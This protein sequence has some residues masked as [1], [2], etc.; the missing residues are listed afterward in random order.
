MYNPTP[1]KVWNRVQN[2]CS[3]NLT[4]FVNPQQQMLYKGNILQ[5][6]GNSSSITKNQR[7][8]QIAK[9]KWTSRKKSWATQSVTYSN[10]NTSNL[11]R[12]NYS[13]IPTD[14]IND[15]SLNTIFNG[16]SLICS[17][18]A[19]SCTN[20]I[21]KQ[22]NN[23]ILS[24]NLTSDSDVPGPLKVL[25]W[26]NS[27]PTYFPR[28]TYK[29]TSV[30]NKFPVNYKGLISA[31]TPIPPILS[32]SGFTST[33]IS[34][35]WSFN[36]N[37]CIIPISSYN[38]YQNG[39]IINNV[40]FTEMSI[41]ISNLIS[42]I[43]YNFYITSLSNTIE[44]L[45]SNTITSTSPI[46]EIPIVLP[47]NNG[48]NNTNNNTTN[49]TNTYEINTTNLTYSITISNPMYTHYIIE[50][51]TNII[52]PTQLYDQTEFSILNNTQTIITISTNN[53]N[54]LIFNSPYN[55]PDGLNTFLINSNQYIK[56]IYSTKNWYVISS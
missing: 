50:S 32:L 39:Q 14:T 7:Y 40:P 41:T 55:P 11:L 43:T 47:I 30:G 3:L 18:I 2:S 38:I 21:I 28:Q 24:C 10:P 27:L 48:N 9:G 49:N 25:C 44:S 46:E 36:N 45:P 1:T 8:A 53:P 31:I 12:V 6:K 51:N 19:N 34:L 56:I 35:F 5:Y 23:S 52:L 20:E 29:M 42:S 54:I 15:C 33:S 16:G 17:T 4:S 26:N 13:V 37:N 22:N